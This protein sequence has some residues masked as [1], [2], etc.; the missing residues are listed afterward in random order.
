MT[1]PKTLYCIAYGDSRLQS[2]SYNSHYMIYSRRKNAEKALEK[3][4]RRYGQGITTK[5]T[6]IADKMRIVEYVVKE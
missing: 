5:L 1:I 6:S 2:T 3:L 4:K